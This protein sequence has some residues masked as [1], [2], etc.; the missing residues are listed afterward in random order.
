MARNLNIGGVALLLLVACHAKA[1]VFDV[2]KNG[3][4]PSADIS[5]VRKCIVCHELFHLACMHVEI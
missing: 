4:T 3:A 1:Q 5:E 2:T